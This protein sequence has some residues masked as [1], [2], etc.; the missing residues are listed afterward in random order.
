MDLFLENFDWITFNSGGNKEI[1]VNLGATCKILTTLRCDPL[2]TVVIATPIV[3][4]RYLR[5]L[6]DKY[7]ER[8]HQKNMQ[9]LISGLQAL[10]KLNR[11]IISYLKMRNTSV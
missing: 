7:L 3:L 6:K 10:Y 9:Q 4:Y 5:L 1:D 8:L 11:R 2:V